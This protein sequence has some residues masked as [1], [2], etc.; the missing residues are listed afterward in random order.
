[1]DTA[2]STA[3]EPLDFSVVTVLF[4]ATDTSRRITRTIKVPKS[5]HAT[6]RGV[7]VSLD[8]SLAGVLTVDSDDVYWLLTPLE[9]LTAPNDVILSVRGGGMLKT[10]PLRVFPPSFEAIA[11]NPKT[12]ELSLLYGYGQDD[13]DANTF[14]ISVANNSGQ[15]I[16]GLSITL[17][18][19]VAFEVSTSSLDIPMNGTGTFKVKPKIGLSVGNYTDRVLVSAAGEESAVLLTL[20]VNEL[21][22]D[23]SIALNPRSI[24]FPQKIVGYG[25]QPPVEFRV[26]N[27]GKFTIDLLELSLT[28]ANKNDFSISVTSLRDLPVGAVNA[29]KFMVVPKAGLNVGE[30]TATVRI[31]HNGSELEELPMSFRVTRRPDSY[32]GSSGGCSVGTGAFGLALLALLLRR[33]TRN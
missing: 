32:E 16:N 7:P 10:F 22:Q 31:L 21:R 29:K 18:S 20:Q 24:A 1:L 14:D 30:H 8:V 27:D 13:I 5:T 2:F 12:C 11:L 33:K 9:S 26:T 6:A 23:Y 28:G 4:D 25:P 3:L 19:G 15:A 17:E